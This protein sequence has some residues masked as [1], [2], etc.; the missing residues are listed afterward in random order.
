M[1]KFEFHH[2]MK[3]S[4]T[5][6]VIVTLIFLLHYAHL[7]CPNYPQTLQISYH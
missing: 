2:E 5:C 4:V 7:S 1:V 3:I 6:H